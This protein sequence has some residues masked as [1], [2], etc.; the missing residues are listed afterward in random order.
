VQSGS[1]T[2][3]VIHPGWTENVSALD[4]W[5]LPAQGAGSFTA[6]FEVVADRAG[7]LTET[8]A[9]TINKP[10]QPTIAG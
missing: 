1:G 7:T 2:D 3:Y 9:V 8:R 6:K 4:M 5:V 10:E